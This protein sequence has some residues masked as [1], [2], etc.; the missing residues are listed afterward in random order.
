MLL[1][2]IIFWFHL[3]ITVMKDIDKTGDNLLYLAFRKLGAY[4]DDEPGYFGHGGLASCIV[5]QLHKTLLRQG[6]ASFFKRK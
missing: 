5:L 2:E 4:P 6:E 1:F 3:W